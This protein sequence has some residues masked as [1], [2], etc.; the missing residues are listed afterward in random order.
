MKLVNGPKLIFLQRDQLP[1][2][3]KKGVLLART[4]YTGMGGAPPPSWKG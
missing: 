2:K 1:T 3:W 4:P